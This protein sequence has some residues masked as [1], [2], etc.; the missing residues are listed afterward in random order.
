ML[1]S[2]QLQPGPAH[3][4]S[5]SSSHCSP[6]PRW[7]H[8]DRAGHRRRTRSPSPSPCSTAAPRVYKTT[9]RPLGTLAPSSPPSFWTERRRRVQPWPT[10][11]SSCA[12]LSG[13]FPE[14][15]YVFPAHQF[16]TG[17][18]GCSPSSC[19]LA[20]AAA[21]RRRI[22]RAPAASLLQ[23]ASTSSL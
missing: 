11:T 5:P 13:S 3:S 19:P 9:P 2:V 17:R 1:R 14:L 8:G 12:V 20:T 4:P 10:A 23:T 16:G 22:R 15:G 7:R 18:T 21:P 6:V